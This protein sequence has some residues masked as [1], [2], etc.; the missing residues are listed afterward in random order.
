M[1]R[2]GHPAGAVGRKP[3]RLVVKEYEGFRPDSVQGQA[4]GPL[5][6]AAVV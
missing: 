6:F 1:G 4:N 2:W 5:N 3:Y